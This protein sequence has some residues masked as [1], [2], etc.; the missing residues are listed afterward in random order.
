MQTLNY[1][2]VLQPE[3]EG[4][5]TVLVPAFPG[6]ISYGKTISE[7]KKMAEDAIRGYIASIRKHHEPI[8]SDNESFIASVQV[9]TLVA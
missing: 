7:A 4:G 9:R 1:N 8:P 3:K 2:I 5:F 6:C